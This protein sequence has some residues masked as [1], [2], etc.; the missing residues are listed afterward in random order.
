MFALFCFLYYFE[1]NISVSAISI[2]TYITF[3]KDIITVRNYLAS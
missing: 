3:F 1:E 2:G